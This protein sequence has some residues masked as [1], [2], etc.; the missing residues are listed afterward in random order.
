MSKT[1]SM[2]LGAALVAAM[3][4][5]ANPA[6]AVE[7]C[8]SPKVREALADCSAAAASPMAAA[9]LL[10][11]AKQLQSRASMGRLP[12][13]AGRTKLAVLTARDLDDAETKLD[14]AFRRF[15]CDDKPAPGDAAARDRNAEIAYARA[16][17]HYSENRFEEAAI[18]FGDL[19]LHRA[20]TPVGV[21]A[22]QLYLESI[23]VLGSGGIASCYDDMARDVPAFAGLYCE[24]GKDKVN[25]DECGVLSKIQRDI[26]RL[27]AEQRIQVADRGGDDAYATYEAGGAMYFQIWEQYGKA[28]CEGKSAGCERMEEILYNAARAYQA[29]R[30]IDRSIAIRKVLID[31][32]YHLDATELAKKARYEIAGSYHAM[33]FYDEAATWYE[34]F[35]RATPAHEK[36]PEALMDATVLRLG[37]GQIAQAEANAGEL[38]R[39]YG[40]KK[41]A[42]TAQIAYA[43]AMS[44]LDHDDLKGAKKRFEAAM[45]MIDRNARVDVQILAHAGLAR[46]LVGLHEDVRAAAEYEK[47]RASYR[48]PERVIKRLQQDYS[49]D[50]NRPVARVLTAVGEAIFFFAEAKRR[51]AEAI[52]RPVYKGAGERDDVLKFVNRLVSTWIKERRA[53]IEGAEK[54]Y[55]EVLNLQPMAPPKWVV[56]SASRVARMHARLRVELLTLPFPKSWKAQGASPWGAPWEEI[57]AAFRGRLDEVSEPME[58]RAKAAFKACV[59]TSVRYQ[60]FDEHASACSAW[61]SSHYPAEFP[62][63]DEIIDRPSHRY[64]GVESGLPVGG[65]KVEPGP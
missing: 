12:G 1:T 64:Y 37:L 26:L 52:A 7:A 30:N 61:L 48:D 54:A 34:S 16:R 56:A 32:R 22:S 63:L 8:L 33:A 2:I 35:A 43:L 38:N 6:R 31:P 41:P 23:N 13:G 60:Y 59:N 36:A 62:R 51:E 45:A 47:V 39:T 10:A 28:A 57:R 5:G 40:S 11:A 17:L 9:D 21:F 3:S 42:Q 18:L 20:D 65:V 14:G 15:L 29:A 49:G 27:H 24:G 55:A 46:A 4:L 58:A 53:A 25:V 44:S 19:A 50:E